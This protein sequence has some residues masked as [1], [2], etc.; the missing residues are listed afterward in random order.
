VP[1]LSTLALAAT[2]ACLLIILAG[3]GLQTDEANKDLTEANKHQAEAEAIMVRLKAFPTDWQAILNVSRVTQAEIDRARQLV[4]ARETDL[5]ALEKALSEWGKDLD[6]ISKLNV[7]MKIKEYVRLKRSAIK[8]WQDYAE[9]SLRP[10]INAYSGMVEII[11]YGRPPS[12]QEAKA[13]EITSLAS[14][15]AQKLEE[16]RNLEKQAGDYFRDNKLGK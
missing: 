8:S 4:Q 11:A 16:I 13:Q 15:S 12:E 1:C 9:S 14:E 6:L 3:C 7:E 5:D 10:L 2:L